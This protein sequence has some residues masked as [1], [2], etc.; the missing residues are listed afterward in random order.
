MASEWVSI[1]LAWPVQVPCWRE[2]LNRT[3][4]PTWSGQ[5]QHTST[6]KAA[7]GILN[8]RQ[9][10]PGTRPCRLVATE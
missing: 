6:F 5:Q 4:L 2:K 3:R 1:T 8:L 7:T 9:W 10:V